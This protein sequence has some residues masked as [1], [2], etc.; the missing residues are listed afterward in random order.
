VEFGRN[1]D[2]QTWIIAA[3]F[4][5]PLFVLRISLFHPFYLAWAFVVMFI[6]AYTIKLIPKEEVKIEKITAK[7]NLKAIFIGI[8]I[9]LAIIILFA[10]IF[11][12]L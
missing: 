8:G 7:G 1:L 2:A 11:C 12:R 3:V 5:I 6:D 9:A 10:V 4:A